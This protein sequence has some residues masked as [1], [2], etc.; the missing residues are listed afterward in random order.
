[1][2]SE[3]PADLYI[4]GDVEADGPIPGR[5]SMLSFG[6]CVAGRF[7]GSDFKPWDP[8]TETFY[9]ELQPISEQWDPEALSV[10]RLD[11]DRLKKTGRSPREAM[12]EAAR[13]VQ[14]V[15]SD[16]RAV[17]VGFPAAFDWMFLYWYFVAF[18]DGG[19]P[20]DFSAVLDTK[21]M[22]QQKARVVTSAAGLK[23]LPPSLRSRHPHTHNA[24]DDAIEQ[25]DVFARLFLWDGL[26]R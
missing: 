19:S 11:R 5:Y 6:L 3:S 8:R 10:A 20:F 18:A 15:A 22:F 2:R 14:R 13:W 4:S 12:T 26:T 9:V 16:D 7:D 24:L 17:F 21:T 1:M 25:A 23:D